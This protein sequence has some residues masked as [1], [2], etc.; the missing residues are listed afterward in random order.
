MTSGTTFGLVKVWGASPTEV[1]ASNGGSIILRYNGTTWS[2]LT[3]PPPPPHGDVT[4]GSATSAIAL[5][6]TH[7][8]QDSVFNWNGTTWSLVGTGQYLSGVWLGADGRGAV[9]DVTTQP[10]FGNAGPG[11]VSSSYFGFRVMSLTGKSYDNLIV[12]RSGLGMCCE[13]DAPGFGS[14]RMG[15]PFAYLTPLFLVSSNELYL[16]DSGKLKRVTSPND[17]TTIDE[18]INAVSMWGTSNLNLFLVGADGKI[19]RR[20]Q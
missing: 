13:I 11:W 17:T 4:I 2:P 16:L 18:G 9:S 5:W 1:Y 12:Q 8:G 15:A 10:G 20:P 14:T 19:Y 3:M 6:A 7:G